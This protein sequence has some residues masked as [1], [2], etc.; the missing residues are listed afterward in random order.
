MILVHIVY[1]NGG[2]KWYQECRV[3]NINFG[4]TIINSNILWSSPRS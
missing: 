1:K 4:F 3:D 2:D